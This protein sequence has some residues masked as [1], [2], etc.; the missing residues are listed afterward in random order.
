LER[1]F[2]SLQREEAKL[3]MKKAIYTEKDVEKSYSK[4]ANF[5]SSPRYKYLHYSL[6]AA[7]RHL[8]KA[9]II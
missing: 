7:V 9:D 5:E 8:W 1:E 4:D 3:A 2:F 6:I